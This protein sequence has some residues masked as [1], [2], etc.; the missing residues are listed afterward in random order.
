MEA[1]QKYLDHGT[2]KN[3][4]MKRLKVLSSFFTKHN[5]EVQARKFNDNGRYEMDEGERVALKEFLIGR[6]QNACEYYSKK[7]DSTNLLYIYDERS[8]R[9]SREPNFVTGSPNS[10]I[11]HFKE[12]DKIELA[13]IQDYQ[14][15]VSDGKIISQNIFNNKKF[16]LVEC[17]S[18][19]N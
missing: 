5:F 11:W 19:K 4:D 2:L 9:F 12:P 8:I 6:R 17:Q 10:D 1:F 14:P 15:Q 13:E 18:K 16:V 3:V 7:N